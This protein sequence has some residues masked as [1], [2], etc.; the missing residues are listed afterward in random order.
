[1]KIQYKI[2]SSYDKE[3]LEEELNNFIKETKDISVIKTQFSTVYNCFLGKSLFECN[4]IKYSVLLS[5]SVGNGE[6]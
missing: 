4:P 3:E 2:F 1:M 6:D 5:Y